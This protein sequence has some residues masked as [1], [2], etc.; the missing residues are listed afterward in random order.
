[1]NFGRTPPPREVVH[2]LV[3]LAEMHCQKQEEEG[4]EPPKD[5]LSIANHGGDEARV[6]TM[7]TIAEDI[8][9]LVIA[10]L[11]DV[12]KGAQCDSEA[13]DLADSIDHLRRRIVK[14]EGT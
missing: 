2:L 13:L 7:L 10:D 8:L 5:L 1:M 9:W 14:L 11:P 4:N 12:A 6:S 3:Q